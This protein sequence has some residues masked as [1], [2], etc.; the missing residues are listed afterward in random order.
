D[1]WRPKPHPDGLLHLASLWDIP[2]P[3]VI[4]VGDSGHDMATGRAAGVGACIGLTGGAGSAQRLAHEADQLI[5]DL[6]HITL[7]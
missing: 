4:M 5:P 6:S 1:H 7:T 2:L 3:N